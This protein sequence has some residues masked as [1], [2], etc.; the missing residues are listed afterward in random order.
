MI[1]WNSE[2]NIVSFR[3]MIRPFTGLQ[4]VMPTFTDISE[5]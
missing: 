5:Q 2:G 4:V 1:H 3:A